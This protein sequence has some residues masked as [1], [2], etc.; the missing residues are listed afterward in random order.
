MFVS[1]LKRQYLAYFLFVLGI[2]IFSIIENFQEHSFT[3]GVFSVVMVS[4]FAFLLHSKKGIYVQ[5]GPLYIA[6]RWSAG[7][8]CT[9]F[10]FSLRSN[11]TPL[12]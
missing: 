10:L 1:R 6:L 3:H 9:L 8:L 7:P 2:R 4:V 5:S 12:A 11:I